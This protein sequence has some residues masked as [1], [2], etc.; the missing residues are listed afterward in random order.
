MEEFQS[1][2]RQHQDWFQ[3]PTPV[4]SAHIQAVEQKLGLSFP[5][6]LV[7]LLTTMGY[8]KGSGIQALEWIAASCARG[9]AVA[10]PNSQAQWVKIAQ[11][12]LEE[13]ERWCGHKICESQTAKNTASADEP[14]TAELTRR[15]S[16]LWM[17][18]HPTPTAGPLVW[19]AGSLL[20]APTQHTSSPLVQFSSY[21]EYVTQRY[22]KY[23]AVTPLVYQSCPVKRIPAGEPLPAS[24]A[25]F[26][27]GTF[28]EKLGETIS[29]N[30]LRNH[31]TIISE[32][33]QRKKLT[34]DE[35]QQIRK[36]QLLSGNF[37][38]DPAHYIK[39]GS[40]NRAFIKPAENLAGGK[41]LLTELDAPFDAD[42]QLAAP[43]SSSML[44]D[45]GRPAP[46][47]WI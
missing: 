40:S 43:L 34:Y 4:R 5:P 41:L 33:T 27:W 37:R 1:F 35:I 22:A 32:S 8:W 19:V 44:D 7:W 6:S 26:P 16:S 23:H 9:Q 24:S 29:W 28:A 3:G 39:N 38:T 17:Q 36:H 47:Y 13:L 14:K 46:D 2:V 25:D 10:V 42:I 30:F 21:M 31:Q 11:P 20:P 18:L 45:A 15:I 12:N